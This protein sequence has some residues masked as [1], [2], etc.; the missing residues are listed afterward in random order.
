MP[1]VLGLR[2]FVAQTFLVAVQHDVAVLNGYVVGDIYRLRDVATGT[3]GQT[4]SHTTSQF[5]HR[6]LAH[7]IDKD[8]GRRIAKDARAQLV[9]PIIV[10]GES[11]QGGL[12]TTQN[13]GYIGIEL[14]QN[15]GIDN[16]RIVRTEAVP[17]IR[18][19][20]ILGTQTTVGCVFVDHRVHVARRDGKI[21]SWAPQLLEVAEVAMPVRLRNDSHT[22][23]SSLE[24]SPDDGVGKGRMVDISVG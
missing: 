16:G 22:I 13:N 9:L 1:E 3:D 6:L 8:I 23:A 15:L 4:I 17:T 12:Y 14:A 18:T 19:V 7:A 11:A 24:R 5:Y 20:G 21:Q 10:M 2:A